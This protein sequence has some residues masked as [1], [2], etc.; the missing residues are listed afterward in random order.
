MSRSHLIG[1]AAAIRRS[2][3]CRAVR[4]HLAAADG[5]PHCVRGT[6]SGAGRCR[7]TI[8]T[9]TASRSIRR[10]R[11]RRQTAATIVAVPAGD[12]I[13]FDE[14]GSTP[15]M[16]ATDD[17]SRTQDQVLPQ[18]DGAAR[19]L[20]DAEEGFDGDGLHP[21]LRR[22]R[23]RRRRGQAVARQDPAHR[24]Q[25]RAGRA[26]PRSARLVRAPGTIQLDERRVSVIAM[27]AE[28]FVAEGRRRHHRQRG[29]Q[30][31]A[32]DGDLQ[33]RGGVRGSRIS[34]DHH[35]EDDGR[36]SSPM[37]AVRG[38]GWSIS[39]CPSRSSPRSRKAQRPDHHPLDGPARR[40]RAR[41]QRR[42]RACARS[43]ATCCSASPITRVGLGDGRCCRAR[44][45]QRRRRP[46]GDGARAQL[47]WP[48]LS[49][50]RSRRSIRS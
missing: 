42:S 40:H 43:P 19:H 20:A 50:A 13:S 46:A 35:L 16:I 34:L 37:A 39:T 22:R 49:P 30:G 38:S 18:S 4:R 12:D 26:A 8:R 14:P 31:P 28:S 33:S 36:R 5:W 29:R 17:Q 10:R 48:G 47:S 27:R 2:G 32:A 41:A 23:Q 45:R 9:R 11:R 25:V 44:P 15:E 24:R 1:T 7:S 3:R 6:R 21:R